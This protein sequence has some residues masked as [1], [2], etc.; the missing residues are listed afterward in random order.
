MWKGFKEFV[1]RG[2]VVELG[3]AVIIG[4]AFG[5]VVNSLVADVLTPLLGALGGA[6]D[7]SALRLGPVAIGKFVNAGVNFLIVAAAIYFLVVVPM[8]RI[9]RL[10]AAQPAPPP[11][12]PPEEVKLLRAILEELQKRG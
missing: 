1:M 7:F 10:K 4:G 6:P 5:Q 3:V 2:N 11:P 8:E 9:K 12:E